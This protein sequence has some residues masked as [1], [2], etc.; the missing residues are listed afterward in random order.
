LHVRGYHPQSVPELTAFRGLRYDARAVDDISAVLC[1]PYDV[2]SAEER[3]RL[4]ALDPRN[5]VN[6]ELPVASADGARSPYETAASTV[7]AWLADGTLRRDDR[8]MIYVYEQR[9]SLA[10]GVELSAIGFFCRLRLEAYGPESAVLPHEHTM[11]GPKA[12][13][14]RLL[15]AVQANLSPVLFLYD[16][17]EHGAGSAALIGEITARVPDVEGVGPGGLVNRLWVVDPDESAAGRRLMAAAGARPVYIADGHH[18]YET[19]LRYQS[20]HPEAPEAGFVLSLMYDAHSGGLALLP[21]HRLL[22]G[23]DPRAVL[24]ALS[25]WFSIQPVDSVEDL[26]EALSESADAGTI[27]LWTVESQAVLR[28]NRSHIEGI[29]PAAESETL[30]WLDVSVLSSTLTKMFGIDPATLADDGRLTY[31]AN[32][33]AAIA[34]VKAGEADVAFLLRPTPIDSVLAVSEARGYM[35]AKSTFFHPKAATGLVFNP[36]A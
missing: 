19:A 30:R 25:P 23:I 2:I 22:R 15:T 24:G 28:V 9:Y 10:D 18:R 4:A 31:T 16:D 36:L 6:V 32:T 5:A 21:W 7:A 33:R 17:G 20:E 13:R 8:P 29:L 35:P 3:A 14:F 27:G 12:D 1:P 26:L 34:A 11:S